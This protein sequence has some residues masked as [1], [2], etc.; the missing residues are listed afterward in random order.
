M[1]SELC[2]RAPW[3][4]GQSDAWRIRRYKSAV[5]TK[6]EQQIRVF[7][8]LIALHTAIGNFSL[9]VCIINNAPTIGKTTDVNN[10]GAILSSESGQVFWSPG[11]MAHWHLP[12]DADRYAKVVE[13]CARCTVQE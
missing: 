10:T 7:T 6:C 9:K 1:P 3:V 12:L 13:D 5:K 4:T 8:H 2:V 11:M